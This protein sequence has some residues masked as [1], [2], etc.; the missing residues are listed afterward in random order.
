MK[1]AALADLR[2]RVRW[3]LA[4]AGLACG[5]LSAV[6]IE[7]EREQDYLGYAGYH[8][9]LSIWR[10]IGELKVPNAPALPLRFHFDSRDLAEQSLLGPGWTAPLLESRLVRKSQNVLV[11]TTLA[12][13][14]VT[15]R[16]DDDG[17]AYRSTNG[18][19]IAEANGQTIS[20]VGSEQERYV[21]DGGRIRE[22]RLPKAKLSW[23]YEG[24]RL[25]GIAQEGKGLIVQVV[26]G[27]GAGPKA[28]V[29]NDRRIQLSRPNAAVLRVTSKGGLDESYETTPQAGGEYRLTL[30]EMGREPRTFAWKA[31]N[32]AIASDGLWAYSVVPHEG[33][34]AEVSRV[35]AAGDREYYYYDHRAGISTHRTG[36]GAVATS[37]FFTGPGPLAGELQKKTH[38]SYW[39]ETVDYLRENDGSGRLLRETEEGITTWHLHPGSD[40]IPAATDRVIK[41]DERGRVI[42]RHV[43][44]ILTEARYRPDGSCLEVTEMPDGRQ[45]KRLLDPAGRLI[46]YF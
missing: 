22:L 3:L 15:L 8:G 7:T 25:Q 42:S 10:D 11:L 1:L 12:G 6:A 41:Y 38:H 5:A 29:V 40:V 31:A 4:S 34:H 2:G 13:R 35:N 17:R 46:A 19:W 16:E 14:S 18:A 36:D 37:Y 27:H 24:E 20:V 28:L 43:N 23:R 30:R 32:S 33:N 21:Y 44:S 45:I 9:E 26:Y 39:L